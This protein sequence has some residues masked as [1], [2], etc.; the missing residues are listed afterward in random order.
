M[1]KVDLTALKFKVKGIKLKVCMEITLN[2]S[3]YTY[4]TNPSGMGKIQN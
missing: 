4:N 1:L 2:F 3:L